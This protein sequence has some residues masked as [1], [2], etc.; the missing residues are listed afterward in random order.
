MLSSMLVVLLPEFL[1]CR[2][3]PKSA[4]PVPGNPNSIPQSIP[5][6][7]SFCIEL[8]LV[9]RVELQTHPAIF[10]TSSKHSPRIGAIFGSL[11]CVCRPTVS[12]AEVRWNA[13]ERATWIQ[14]RQLSAGCVCSEET[15]RVSVSK[16][17]M[18]LHL[19]VEKKVF[20][21][22]SRFLLAKTN[23]V[24]KKVKLLPWFWPNGQTKSGLHGIFHWTRRFWP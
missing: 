4:T 13:L 20:R 5:Q 8:C 24:W 1:S 23:V 11:C 16:E 22:L 9:L 10:W 18:F 19:F 3:T 12:L 15:S 2:T 21:N 6:T 14:A 7:S 17:S